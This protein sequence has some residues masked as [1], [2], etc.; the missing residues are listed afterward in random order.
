MSLL[1]DIK[2]FE[3][4]ARPTTC[5]EQVCWRES[6]EI[7][8][9]S[10]YDLVTP[11]A[12]VV[13]LVLV[14]LNDN[15][16]R[17][18]ALVCSTML[19]LVAEGEDVAN[20][21]PILGA[22]IKELVTAIFVLEAILVALLPLPQLEALWSA[23]RTGKVPVVPALLALLVMIIIELAWQLL[24]RVGHGTPFLNAPLAWESFAAVLVW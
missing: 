3:K 21:L 14:L 12:N 18:V 7:V 2:I 4:A 9:D 1:Q 5:R 22:V 6:F 17:R 15:V 13:M 20:E 19:V 23:P 24:H 16:H 8:Q 10:N 11:H